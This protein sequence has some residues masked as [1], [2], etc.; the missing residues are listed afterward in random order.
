MLGR[1][2]FRSLREYKAHRAVATTERAVR[3]V[4]SIDLRCGKPKKTTA[5]VLLQQP[6][7]CND[8]AIRQPEVDEPCAALRFDKAIFVSYNRSRQHTCLLAGSRS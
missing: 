7:R 8:Q 3:R 1:S 4:R 5:P 6:L 2:G